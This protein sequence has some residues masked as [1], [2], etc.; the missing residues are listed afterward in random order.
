MKRFIYADNAATTKTDIDAFRAMEPFL[1]EEYGNPSAVYSFSRKPKQALMEARAVIASCINA[2][3]QEIYFTSGGT[4]SNNWA[5][6][7]ISDENNPNRTI[8]TSRIEHHSVLRV[9]ETIEKSGDTVIYL[10]VTN[11][12]IVTPESL[13]EAAPA[14]VKLV[15]VMLAN[16]EIGTIEPVKKLCEIAHSLGGVFHTDAVQA[17]GHIEVDVKELGID[18]LSAS[19]HKFNGPRGIG[20]LYI[21]KGTPLN[22]YVNGGMQESGMRAGTENIASIVGMSAAL[23]KNCDAVRENR[24]YILTLENILLGRLKASGLDFIRNGSDFRVPGNISLSF[25]N[26]DG[27]ALLHRLDLMG[28][29]VSAG[30]ACNSGEAE[31]S[32][33]L[34]ATGTEDNYAKGTIRISFGK[35]NTSEEAEIIADSLI[36]ILSSK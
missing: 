17:V 11:E 21:K 16:N 25:N 5:L 10:P 15:S 1:L 18:M 12:G 32:H 4:E 19:A 33:V 2:E 31:V 14:G 29:A 20:F 8:I 24:E 22:A 34:K 28:I 7:C 26:A 23:K 9:C 6:K 35:N 27:E 36:S 13:A 30:S 3:A